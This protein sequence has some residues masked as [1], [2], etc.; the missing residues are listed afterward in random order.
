MAIAFGLVGLSG[1]VG[2]WWTA[3]RW[4]LPVRLAVRPANLLLAVASTT[5]S[6]IITLVPGIMIGTPE[7]F[8]IDEA[9]ADDR[10]RRRL[11]RVGALALVGVGAGAW[12]ITLLTDFLQRADLPR[13]LA[14]CVGG[15]EA[16]LLVVFAVA[17]QKV[18]VEML[19]MEGSFGWALSRRSR[20]LWFATLVLVAFVFWHTLINPRG[21][22]AA[23]LGET[24]VRAVLITIG[25]FSVFS[26]AVWVADRLLRRKHRTTPPAVGP[27]PPADHPVGGPDMPGGTAPSGAP[28]PA[29]SLLTLPPPPEELRGSE[30][31]PAS[32]EA[33]PS[34][35]PVPPV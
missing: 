8:E 16:L 29:P 24:S 11:L 20:P 18:F 13:G 22:L 19:G 17:V 28:A 32:P 1:D 6:R 21:D 35:P 10:Q 12:L 30:P 27:P 3:R 23:A 14:L 26:V 33:P 5:F 25:A 4:G 31:Q 9:A 2:R 15:L 7:A 34:P